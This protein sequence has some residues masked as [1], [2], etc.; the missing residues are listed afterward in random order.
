MTSSFFYPCDVR[1]AFD[2]SAMREGQTVGICPKSAG[3]VKI[4]GFG[5][6]DGACSD[7]GLEEAG[8][9]NTHEAFDLP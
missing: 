8:R 5:G 7:T 6:F 9:V 1:R 4:V 2:W 3:I